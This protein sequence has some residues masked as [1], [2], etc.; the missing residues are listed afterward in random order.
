MPFQLT[1]CQQVGNKHKKNQDTLFNGKAVYQWQLKNAESDILDRENVI[2]GVADGVS[3]SHHSQLASR[4]LM[5]QLSKCQALNSS[6]LRATQFALC[7]KY[8]TSHFGISSTFVGCELHANGK[9]KILNV[10]DSR[11]YKITVN[12]EWQ[13]LSIDHTMLTEMKRQGLAD[14]HTQYASIYNGLT[15]CL[16]ADFE[17]DDFRIHTT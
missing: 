17:A 4:F 6:W 3:H 12:G 11:A 10:G 14:E 5:E 2:F 9:G 1:F 15:D 8:A 13:Q 16:V 7:E